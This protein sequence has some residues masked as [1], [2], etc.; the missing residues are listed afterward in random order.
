MAPSVYWTAQAECDDCGWVGDGR[1][2]DGDIVD[3]GH[4]C[5]EDN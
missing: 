4:E 5:E 3:S 2:E 1:F